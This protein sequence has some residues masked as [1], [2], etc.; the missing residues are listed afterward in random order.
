MTIGMLIES[1]AGKSSALHGCFHDGTPFIF[2]EQLK[3]VDLFARLRY[4]RIN[5]VNYMQYGNSVA[6][7]VVYVIFLVL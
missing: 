1:M 6:L 3:A 5:D 4:T 7:R 2:H